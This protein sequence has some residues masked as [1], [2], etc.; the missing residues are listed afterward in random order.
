MEKMVQKNILII[1]HSLVSHE[2]RKRW[3]AMAEL[4]PQANMTIL[5]PNLWK[6][7]WFGELKTISP[8]AEKYKNY[9]VLPHP[10]SDEQNWNKYRP[11]Y[12]YSLIRKK[13]PDLLI[14]MQ[15]EFT[16]CL[17]WTLFIKNIVSPRTALI[18]FSWQN[19]S[20][21]NKKWYKKI[22]WRWISSK[23]SGMIAGTQ[24]IQKLF[25]ANHYPK[26]ILTQTEIGVDPSHFFPQQNLRQFLRKKWKMEDRFVVGHCGRLVEEK[27]VLDLVS[28][29]LH[30]TYP[31]KWTLLFVGDGPLKETIQQRFQE[32]NCLEQLFITG[33]IPMEQTAEAYQVMDLFV[34]PSKTTPLWKEQFGLVL[35]QAMMVNVPVI[36]SNSGAIPE[37]IGD[38]RFIFP[39]G[40]I[41]SLSQLILDMMEHKYPLSPSPRQRG[42]KYSTNTLAKELK[43]FIHDHIFC[44]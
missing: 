7:N 26:P 4:W 33:Q 2:C 38:E 11:K 25:Q 40:N 16:Y 23:T 31:K 8:K 24:E 35:A 19:I 30:T 1:G 34:L 20:L 44:S 27:G 28:A 22:L 32:H 41:S 9:E 6:Q 37:V 36:G 10:V 13:K 21:A 39:E 5:I 17:L 3:Q 15:E 42:L 14:V 43:D 18:F 29:M 12:L